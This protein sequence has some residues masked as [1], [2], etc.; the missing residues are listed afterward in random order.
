LKNDLEVI[1]VS[2]FSTRV[3]RKLGIGDIGMRSLLQQ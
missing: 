3:T 1:R 2:A